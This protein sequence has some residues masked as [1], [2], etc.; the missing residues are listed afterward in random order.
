MPT[1]LPRRF[2][3]VARDYPVYTREEADGHADPAVRGYRRD[4]RRA[5]RGQYALTDD[6]YVLEVVR[7]DPVK[8]KR[9]KWATWRL[10]T[11]VGYG[12]QKIDRATGAPH[13]GTRLTARDTLDRFRDTGLVT[14]WAE[15]EA[16]RTRAKRAVLLLA[17]LWIAEDGRLTDDSWAMVGQAYRP[18]HDGNDLNAK[19]FFLRS[20]AG[21][22]MLGDAVDR[23]LQ[24]KGITPGQVL[25]RMTDVYEAALKRGQTK[26]AL[27][28]L[29]RMRDLL[30]FKREEAVATAHHLEYADY[31]ELPAHEIAG[32]LG[33]G[34]DDDDA[35]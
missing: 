25:D 13:P 24:E 21:R 8:T 32:L 33:D 34:D 28:V 27:D 19:Q 15:A 11:A 1:A 2:H 23:I 22:K 3:G 5:V 30:D 4:W 26:V 29:D 14:D 16:R 20:D 18:G 12:F 31:D 7:R 6:G 9:G 10:A 35:G 17:R